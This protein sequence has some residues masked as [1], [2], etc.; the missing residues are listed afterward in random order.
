MILT[1]TPN[2]ALDRTAIMPGFALDRVNNTKAFLTQPGGKGINVARVLKAFGERVVATGF[3]GGETGKLIKNGLERSGIATDFAVVAG[4]SRTCLA[5]IDPSRGAITEI[6]EQGPELGAHDVSKLEALLAK[7]QNKAKEMVFSGS[8][9]PGIPPD[10]Y[11][12]WAEAFQRTGGR[13]YIDAKG[14]VLAHAMEGRPYLVKPNQKEAEELL[15]FKLDN[16]TKLLKALNYLMAKATIAIITLGERGAVVGSGA[17]RWWIYA[18]PIQAINAIGSGDA[19]MAGLI[20]GLR[21]QWSLQESARLATAAGA[22]NALAQE[23]AL[24]RL[25]LVDRLLAQTRAE[26]LSAFA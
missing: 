3:I 19:F 1:V 6:H 10:S 18:P 25:E 2:A 16:E 13:A 23:S 26:P 5:I 8:L 9:P 7:Y 12:R 11:R 22:A 21:R 20:V 17:E 24:V 15:G 14:S 4:E